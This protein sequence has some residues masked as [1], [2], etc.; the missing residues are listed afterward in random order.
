[1]A[2]AAGVKVVGTA[3]VL[4]EA[5]LG[6]YLDLEDLEAVL[7]DLIQVL[8]ISPTVVAELLRLAR[9]ARI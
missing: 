5:C 6:A 9:E 2:V 8:W 3:G 4:L 1:M 7:Q